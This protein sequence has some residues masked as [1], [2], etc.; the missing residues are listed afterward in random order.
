MGPSFSWLGVTKDG[1][2]LGWRAHHDGRNARGQA[3]HEEL[4][5]MVGRLKDDLFRVTTNLIIFRETGVLDRELNLASIP[6][7]RSPEGLRHCWCTRSSGLRIISPL[8]LTLFS[9][10]LLVHAKN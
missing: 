6:Y 9:Q 3:D 4:A 10:C 1:N 8:L 7:M 5:H 2:P